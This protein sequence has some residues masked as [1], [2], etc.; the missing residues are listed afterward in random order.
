MFLIR[1]RGGRCFYLENASRKKPLGR[2]GVRSNRDEYLV[3]KKAD[4]VLGYSPST[5]QQAEDS[6]HN[7]A[8]GHERRGMAMWRGWKRI[9]M[10]TGGRLEAVRTLA[11]NNT[12]PG[13]NVE[14]FLIVAYNTLN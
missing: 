2:R 10:W 3:G 13:F 9:C 14:I 6:S 7:G 5:T 12:G 8:E 11:V 4:V 1:A